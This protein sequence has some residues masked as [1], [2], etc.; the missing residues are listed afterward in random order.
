MIDPTVS[1]VI[2]FYRE[3][4]L[5]EEAIQSVLTQTF[6]DFEIILVDNNATSETREIAQSFAKS[7]P[8]II[9]LIHE[10]K[11]GCSS[12][13]NAGIRN[14]RGTF[15][16]TFDGDDVMKPERLARQFDAI[17]DRPDVALV[18]CHHDL[19]SAD[20]RIL[21]N[22]VP[23]LSYGPK[24]DREFKLIV[25]QLFEPF[26]FSYQNSFDLFSGSFLFFRKAN[27]IEIGLFDTRLNPYGNEDYLFSMCMFEKG[28]FILIPESLQYFRYATAEMSRH[29][30]KEKHT[31][32]KLLQEEKFLGILWERYG[33]PFPENRKIFRK[34]I[35]HFLKDYGCNLM[36]LS[37]GKKI[38]R[39]FLEKALRQN[40]SSFEIWKYYLKSFAPSHL[41]PRLFYFE[42]EWN[43]KPDFDSNFARDYMRWP[44]TIP[45]F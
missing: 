15:I 45:P 16:A 10:T 8:S 24:E 30:P 18:S 1:V 11:Q 29:K 32:K 5:L 27:A 28:S 31:L 22:N 4:K 36:R 40:I 33:L 41:H 34:L 14:G 13:R 25:K 37:G 39:I 2:P 12:A 17:R 35:A 26:G 20:G 23:E 42:K 9:R 3:G 44:P 21:K 43:G 6:R 38:G 19:M 7:H